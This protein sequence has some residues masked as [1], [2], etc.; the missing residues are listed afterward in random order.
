MRPDDEGEK[1]EDEHGEDERLVTPER[2]TR[3][4]RENFGDD[5]HAGQDQHVNFR[6][7]EEPEEVLPQERTA[8]AADVQRR[9]VN[10]QAGR[11]EK[12]RPG[13]AIHQLHDRRR[14]ERRK[15][16]QQQKRGHELRPD[17]KRQPHPG[18]ALG[19][20]LDDGGDEVHRAQQR[21]S[22]QET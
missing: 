15:R 14:F 18:H 1:T 9:A 2:L 16:E 22:D 20:Q 7:A 5:A 10:N 4:V 11:Q 8:A 6:M 3:I 17:E 21:R 19:P 12:T 13:H